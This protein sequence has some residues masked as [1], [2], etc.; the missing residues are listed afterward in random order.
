MQWGKLIN[1]KKKNDFSILEWDTSSEPGSSVRW[2]VLLAVL[3]PR[4]SEMCRL[5]AWTCVWGLYPASVGLC[6]D[7]LN[8]LFIKKKKKKKESKK[9]MHFFFSYMS[10][11]LKKLVFLGNITLCSF[12]ASLVAQ[13]VKIH[14]Q[15]RRPGFPGRS[16]GEGSGYT[17]Q[18]SGLQNS[19]D[20][21]IHGLQTVWHDWETFT[22]LHFMIIWNI[23][24]CYFFLF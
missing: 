4:G 8:V 10:Y 14:L 6:Q 23:V 2:S 20:C 5:P 13:L 12:W 15:C 24:C 16:S 7:A 3:G 22:S 18:Y 1:L 17:P 11:T 19:K 21:I 9:V